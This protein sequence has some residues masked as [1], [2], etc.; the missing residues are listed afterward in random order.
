MVADAIQRWQIN[1]SG[2][3][4]GLRGGRWSYEGDD[5]VTFTFDRARFADDVPVDRDRDLGPRDRRGPRRRRDRR[6]RDRAS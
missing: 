3:S 1:Y 5:V 2:A 4:R 6:R